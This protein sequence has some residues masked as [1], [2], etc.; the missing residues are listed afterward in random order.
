MNFSGPKG[1]RSL[2]AWN[3]AVTADNPGVMTRK[4]I[5]CLASN[6]WR[7]HTC[8]GGG[9]RRET[10][11]KIA[12]L[13]RAL[14]IRLRPWAFR[15][16]TG[17]QPMRFCCATSP[18]VAGA[19][20]TREWLLS[21]VFVGFNGQYVRSGYYGEVCGFFCLEEEHPGPANYSIPW[22]LPLLLS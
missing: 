21:R 7:S 8:R 16:R 20:R 2:S 10:A 17:L 3:L 13:R 14:D 12:G 4:H 1:D 19:I 18:V 11:S 6:S 9:T 5:K 22:A 15:P